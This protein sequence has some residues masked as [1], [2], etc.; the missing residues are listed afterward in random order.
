MSLLRVREK[1]QVTLPREV[2]A[3]LHLQT[4]GYLQ[5]TILDDGV[6]I[7]PVAITAPQESKLSKIRRLAQ[8]VPSAYES[9][10]A[11][12]VSINRQRD[13]WSK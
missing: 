3:S 10:D 13:D 11:A 6:L 7:R 4:P 2:M 12:D 5:Y 8:S 1:N 9:M